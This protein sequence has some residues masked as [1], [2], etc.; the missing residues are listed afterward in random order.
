MFKQEKSYLYLFCG[1]ANALIILY[2]L[3]RNVPF[4]WDAYSKS[5]RASWFLS[6][7]F[8][9]WILPTELNAGHPPLW[10]LLLAFT[11][12]LTERTLEYSRLL[13]LIFNLAAFYQ[14]IRFLRDHKSP[15]VPFWALILVLIEP[16]LLAQTTILNNDMMLLFFTLLGLNSIYRNEKILY[17]IALTGVLFSNLRGTSVFASL[18]LID[19]LFYWFQLKKDKQEFLWISYVIPIA[20]FGLFIIYHHQLLGWALKKPGLEHREWAGWKRI[21]K[22]IAAI[23]KSVLETGRIFMFGFLAFLILKFFK[24]QKWINL[25]DRNKRLILFFLVFF[26]VFSALFTVMKNP[27]NPRYY[28]IAYLIAS[29]LCLNLIFELIKK[30]K[31]QKISMIY[32]FIAFLT[33]HLWIYPPTLSQGWD[34]SLAY[35]NYFPIRDKMENYLAENKIS[36]ELVG[37]NLNLNH[38]QFIDLQNPPEILYPE[39]NTSKNKYIIFSNI[40]NATSNEDIHLLMNEW[41]LIESYQQ[42]GV[43][44]NLYKNPAYE[45]K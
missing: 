24:K 33:G 2:F 16:T 42:M 21:F 20:L 25:P 28:M 5:I 26:M 10:E 32:L 22:N 23:G 12:K 39:L 3:T 1:A 38:P 36:K 4:F 14:L 34:T 43:F 19:F 7:N 45:D 17:A 40:E 11:W 37:T 29:L 6:H 9:S 8:S 13:L 15:G 18:F 35:L 31:W 44:V 27:V 41:I 30:V